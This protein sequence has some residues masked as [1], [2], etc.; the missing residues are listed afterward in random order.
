MRLRGG[1]GERAYCQDSSLWR[2]FG[3][4]LPVGRFRLSS[5]ACQ[6]PPMVRTLSG[7]LCACVRRVNCC[8]SVE[9]SSSW[10]RYGR[11]GRTWL[12]R[13]RQNHETTRGRRAWSPFFHSKSECDGRGLSNMTHIVASDWL[14]TSIHSRAALPAAPFVFLCDRPA[15]LLVSHPGLPL[16][17]FFAPFRCQLPR[18][19]E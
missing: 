17:S 15:L 8:R 3:L 11:S 5:L 12:L 14:Y 18:R 19:A 7:Y 9:I 4:P 2:H 10:L 6:L 16:P 1:D 13:N